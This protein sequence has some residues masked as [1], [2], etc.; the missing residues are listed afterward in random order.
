MLGG[1]QILL[2]N[3]VCMEANINVIRLNLPAPGTV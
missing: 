3:S 1:E 2:R